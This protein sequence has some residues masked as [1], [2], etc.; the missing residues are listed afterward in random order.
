MLSYRS[1]DNEYPKNKPR[2]YYIAHKFDFET[3]LPIV[4]NDLLNA[5]DCVLWFKDGEDHFLDKDEATE[6]LNQIQ[7]LVVI[8]TPNFLLSNECVDSIEIK[9]AKDN[10]IPILPIVMEGGLDNL[11]Y[12]KLGTIQYISRHN[13]DVTAISYKKRLKNFLK[14]VLV[15]EEYLKQIPS[16]FKSNLFLSY[17]KKDRKYANELIKTIHQNPNCENIGIWYDEFLVPG[18][19]FD[20]SIKNE[21]ENSDLFAIL[22]TPNLVNE[23]NYVLSTEYP[24]AKESNKTILPI[25]SIKT[26][27]KMLKN[28]LGKVKIIKLKSCVKALIKKLKIKKNKTVDLKEK[29]LLGL[30]YLSGIQ[31]ETDANHGIK[32]ISEC[33]NNGYLDAARK[34]AEIYYHGLGIEQNIDKAIEWQDN[35]VQII[36]TRHHTLPEEQ[37]IKNLEMCID[38]TIDL[39]DYLCEGQRYMEAKTVSLNLINLFILKEETAETFKKL[40]AVYSKLIAVCRM[41]KDYNT[42]EDVFKKQQEILKNVD[43]SDY[44]FLEA[45]LAAYNNYASSIIDKNDTKSFE[46]AKEYYLELLNDIETNKDFPDKNRSLVFIFNNLGHCLNRLNENSEEWFKK[47]I[48]IVEDNLK[49]SQTVESLRQVVSL[50]VSL[51]DAVVENDINKAELY[52]LK[53]LDYAYILLESSKLPDD[54]LDTGKVCERLALLNYN[55][56]SFEKSSIYY[57]KLIELFVPY[58]DRRMFISP[59][60]N[61]YFVLASI[62]FRNLE[63]CLD[64][65]LDLKTRE[66]RTIIFKAIYLIEENAQRKCAEI[67]NSPIKLEPTKEELID[68]ERLANCW[69]FLAMMD[70]IIPEPLQRA[71]NL[72]AFLA[73]VRPSEQEYINMLRELRSLQNLTTKDN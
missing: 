29:Y 33:A 44:E 7:L 11:F 37:K 20:E 8:I 53:A 6:T 71:F 32:L 62:K 10:H 39:V 49:N 48:K 60:Y 40:L 50:Y 66:I 23:E 54:I 1:R 56:G 59:L 18:E 14:R 64:D 55:K 63:F 16:V 51:A 21:I 4:T 45:K 25:L 34:M 26:D 15:K 24:L 73:K 69:Y 19:K 61:T 67:I 65:E 30:A 5:C 42:I 70:R 27:I 58:E 47:S 2:V 36:D 17:R 72:W 43:Y 28:V 52:Y 12:E 13:D 3:Y 31:V 68:V 22:V 38:A 46:L 41:L 57:E 9:Y 35:Y